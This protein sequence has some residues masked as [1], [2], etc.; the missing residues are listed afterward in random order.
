MNTKG[1]IV[2]IYKNTVKTLCDSISKTLEIHYHR[3]ENDYKNWQLWVWSIYNSDGKA[4]N[5]IRKDEYGAVFNLNLEKFRPDDKIGILP[6][7]G[8]WIDKDGPEKILN[9]KNIKN[10]K[11]YII[12]QSDKIFNTPPDT[13]PGLINA[14]LDSEKKL[15]ISLSKKIDPKKLTDNSKIVLSGLPK[16]IDAPTPVQNSK[17]LKFQSNYTNIFE[18]KNSIFSKTAPKFIKFAK[19]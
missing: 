19:A 4:I 10:K 5:P 3:H 6:R 1:E 14:F 11:I 18:F 17:K 2:T 12:Q 15:I 9:L 7:K 13:S 16:N 8:N